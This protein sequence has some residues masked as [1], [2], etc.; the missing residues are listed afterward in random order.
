VL[1]ITTLVSVLGVAAGSLGTIWWTRHQAKKRRRI[2]KIWPLDERPIMNSGEQ[3]VWRHLLQA[4]RGH[5]VMIK[6]PITRF[7]VPRAGQDPARLY[8]L[9][10][11]VY[12]TF[13]LCGHD[14]R[15][16]GCIDV[17][18]PQGISKGNR[19]LKLGLLFQC[20][21]TYR[22]INPNELPKA[23]DLLKE[24]LGSRDLIFAPGDFTPASAVHARQTLRAVVSRER[25]RREGH[26]QLSPGELPSPGAAGQ[27][28][29]SGNSGSWQQPNSFIAPLDSRTAAVT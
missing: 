27:F 24:F 18:G 2:P 8:G 22:V 7:T 19:L 23:A 29:E 11:D 10:G 6:L 28:A 17:N 13:T 1:L 20:G 26:R 16:I 3:K 21:I 14:G 25:R 12:C 9:L 4:F 15:V 5:H